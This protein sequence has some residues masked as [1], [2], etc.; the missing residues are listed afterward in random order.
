MRTMLSADRC[1]KV[2]SPGMGVALSMRTKVPLNVAPE[3]ASGLVSRSA[4]PDGDIWMVHPAQGAPTGLVR[5]TSRPDMLAVTASIG[6]PAREQGEG[7]GLGLVGPAPAHHVQAV[8]GIDPGEHDAVG[9]HV[10]QDAVAGERRDAFL[11]AECDAEGAAG[12]AEDQVLLVLAP[13]QGDLHAAIDA[14]LAGGRR[15]AGLQRRMAGGD[16]GQALAAGMEGQDGLLAAGLGDDPGQR[17]GLGAALDVERV[18]DEGVLVDGRL[19]T[20]LSRKVWV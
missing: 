14:G 17:P 20:E 15:E 18:G 8:L 19:D 11:A 7:G 1:C 13:G 12:R 4:L 9:G 6:T 16:R 5:R 3:A 10:L 2:P